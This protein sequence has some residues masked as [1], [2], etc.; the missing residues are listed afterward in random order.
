MKT[1]TTTLETVTRALVPSGR[2]GWPCSMRLRSSGP[3]V[4]WEEDCMT[5]R[6]WLGSASGRTS[7]E[8][9]SCGAM[10]CQGSQRKRRRELLPPRREPPGVLLAET[11]RGRR[12]RRAEGPFQ[13]P[14]PLTNG[15]R[16]R[17]GGEDPVAAAVSLRPAKNHNVFEALSR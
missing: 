3:S 17:G 11:L 9:E 6:L 1:R 10:A 7:G 8:S 16:R 14:A 4:I 12:V 5:S 13:C 15:D 2:R